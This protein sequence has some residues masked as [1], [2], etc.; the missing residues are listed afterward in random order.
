MDLKTAS[1]YLNSF[2]NFERFSSL[3]GKTSWDLRTMRRLLRLFGHPE[4]DFFPVLIA[5]TKGKGSTGYFLETA[6]VAAGIPVGFYSSPHL[7]DPRERIRIQ[8]KT[9]GPKDWT[10]GLS[11]IRGRLSRKSQWRQAD[12]ITFFEVM[13]LLAML[14]FKKNHCRIGIFEVGMGGR[15]DATNVLNAKLAILTPIHLD[16]ENILGPTIAKIACEK[17]A[18]IKPRA[19]VVVSPQVSAAQAVIRSVAVRQKAEIF[20]V[21]VRQDL[22]PGLKGDHQKMNASA[23]WEAV[24]VLREKFGWEIGPEGFSKAIRAQ[25]WPGRLESF[26]GRYRVLVDGAHNPVSIRALVRYLKQTGFPASAV[27]IFGT[28]RDKNSYEMLRVLGRYFSTVILTRFANPRAQELGTL[29]REARGLFGNI[30]PTGN[31]D[32]ALELAFRLAPKG[33]CILAT[34]S[35]YLVGEIRRILGQKKFRRKP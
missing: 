22:E 2:L 20:P 33:G 26:F 31:T 15:L 23:A 12:P 30:F 5:G 10:W 11:R 21:K 24:R 7:E 8:G 14:L 1:R 13:T 4:K 32:S 29:A 27:L 9:I 25:Q 34:G 3:T 35:F 17:A 6:L 19:K 28:S 18:I 16:H